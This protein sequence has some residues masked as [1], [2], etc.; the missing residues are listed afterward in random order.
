MERLLASALLCA[1]F[2]PG[3]AWGQETEALAKQAQNPIASLISVPFQNNFNFGVGPNDDLQYTLNIQPVLPFKLNDSWNVIS[4]TVLPLV[5]QP[6]LAPGVGDTFGLGDIQEQLYFSPNKASSFIWGVGPVLQFPS[7]TDMTL[8]F[9]KW[10]A[11]PGAVGLI[12]KG[13]WVAGALAN[14]I[15]SYA[16]DDD[17]MDVNVLTVQP[18]VNYNLPDG[19]YLTTS[20]IITA[21]WEAN[22][23]NRW[24]VPIGG[25]VGKIFRIGTQPLNA[26]LASYYNIEHPDGAADWQIRFQIQFLFPK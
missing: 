15:W 12:M 4:R 3:P 2:L 5:Y 17:R 25:G 11:G 14:N 23:D 19:W 13:P 10:A 6:V 18:F 21:N 1:L 7:A 9:G 8:G 24:T 22:S 16:G 20:P 26:Q